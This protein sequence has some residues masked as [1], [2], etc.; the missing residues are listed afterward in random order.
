MDVVFEPAD[1]GLE[2]FEAAHPGIG[3]GQRVIELLLGDNFGFKKISGSLQVGLGQL[4][5]RPGFAVLG[6]QGLELM[7]E[8]RGVQASQHLALPDRVAFLNRILDHLA[9]D[10]ACHKARSKRLDGPGQAYTSLNFALLHF[11]E[12]HRGR[13]VS[14]GL[15]AEGKDRKYQEQSKIQDRA[16][17]RN[18]S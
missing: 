5:P 17:C 10:L 18:S 2:L 15:K 6:F 8:R 16:S 12:S 3:F 4:Q 11:R 7:F 14:L 1:V 9:C 13:P